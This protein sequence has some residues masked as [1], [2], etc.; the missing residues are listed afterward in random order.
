MAR[1]AA[2]VVLLGEGIGVGR[3]VLKVIGEHGGIVHAAA[4]EDQ[5]LREVDLG[6]TGEPRVGVE[7]GVEEHGELL[8]PLGVAAH[9]HRRGFRPDSAD[10]GRGPG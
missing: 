2:K 6:L 10:Y 5:I 7:L 3:A 8:V 1:I 9:V 4:A